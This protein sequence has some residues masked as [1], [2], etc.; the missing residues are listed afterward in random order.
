MSDLL[1]SMVHSRVRET[2]DRGGVTA[3]IGADRIYRRSL[4]AALDFAAAM[5][6]GPAPGKE[7]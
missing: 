6:D 7:W 3:R 1:A 4:A 2:L 5:G